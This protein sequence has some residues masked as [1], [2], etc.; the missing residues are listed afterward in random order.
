MEINSS[1]K[2]VREDG[3]EIKKEKAKINELC[4]VRHNGNNFEVESKLK[5]IK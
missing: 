5:V 1:S 4:I 2:F 3:S